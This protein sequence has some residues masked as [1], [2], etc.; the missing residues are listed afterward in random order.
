MKKIKVA[1]AGLG[2]CAS[3]LIQGI[4]Y[5][6]GKR[7][8]EVIGTHFSRFYPPQKVDSGF[9]QYELEQAA[10]KGVFDDLFLAEDHLG[11]FLADVRDIGQRL[12]G[13]GDDRLFIQCGIGIWHHAHGLLQLVLAVSCESSGRVRCMLPKLT[14]WPEDG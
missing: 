8:E 2:N 4:H 10:E 1:I 12:L 6:R 11:D 5:Y 13:L 9:P 14:Y 3:S 7:P